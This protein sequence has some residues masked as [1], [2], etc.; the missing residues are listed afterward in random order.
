MKL[1]ASTL[2][3]LS[4]RS[5]AIGRRLQAGQEK[6]LRQLRRAA[7]LDVEIGRHHRH[8]ALQASGDSMRSE[9]LR[10]TGLSLFP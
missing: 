2:W 5:P 3:L 1:S 8:D 6:P 7:D 4:I 10:E 9:Y